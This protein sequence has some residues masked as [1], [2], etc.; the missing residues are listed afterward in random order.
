[1]R[2]GR[3][4]PA[5]GLAP[6]DDLSELSHTAVNMTHIT[7]NSQTRARIGS[8]A[9]VNLERGERGWIET[10]RFDRDDFNVNEEK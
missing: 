4:A 10:R 5:P 9:E 6:L 1:M 3:R 7:T 8:S 2:Y